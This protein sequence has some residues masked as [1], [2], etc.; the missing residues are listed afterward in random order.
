MV[1]GTPMVTTLLPGMPIEYTQFVYLFHD[2]SVN[3]IYLTLR[4]LL[5]KSRKEL[6]EF[7]LLAKQFALGNKSNIKQSE[8]VLNFDKIS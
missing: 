7:G 6:H 8:R 5:K 4:S 3:G 2:E 1:S